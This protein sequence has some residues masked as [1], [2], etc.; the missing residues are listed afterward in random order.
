ML[1]CTR[2]IYKQELL[3][4]LEDVLWMCAVD[5]YFTHT[6]LKVP[7]SSSKYAA[8]TDDHYNILLAFCPLLSTMCV[9]VFVFLM[10]ISLCVLLLCCSMLFSFH[11]QHTLLDCCSA[12]GYLEQCSQILEVVSVHG[13]WT[14]A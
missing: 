1:A 9:C 5:E 8:P 6:L 3:P 14:S 12:F 7:I 2:H 10:L 13:V 11:L 4:E